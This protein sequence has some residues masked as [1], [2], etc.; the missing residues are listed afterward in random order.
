MSGLKNSADALGAE[1]ATALYGVTGRGIKIGIIS[2]SY[3]VNGSAAANVAAGNLPHNVTVESDSFVGSD[4]GQAMTELAYQ[5]APGASY[6]FATCG[7]SLQS[8]AAAVTTLQNAGCAVIVDDVTFPSEESFYQTGTVL[9]LAI[10]AAVAAGA[11]YFTA[12]GN[13]G[14]DYV[15]LGF[16]PISATVAGISP[17][18]LNAADFGGSSPYQ[19][20]AISPGADVTIDLEWAQPFATIGEGSGGAQNSLAFYLINSAG[21]VVASSTQVMLGDDPVQTIEFTNFTSSAQFRLVVVENGGTTPS[22][23]SFT[24]NVLDSALAT[25][26]GSDVG[27]GTGSVMGHALISGVNAVGA[28]TYNDTP[29]FGISP[30]AP[31]FYSA[32]GPGTILYSAQGQLLPIPIHANAPGFLSVSGSSTTVAGFAPFAGTSAAAPNAAAVGAL[33]LQA[34]GA[35]TNTEL[36]ALLDQSAIPVASTVDDVGA[37]LIQARAAVELSVAAAGARWSAA[38]GVYWSTTARWSAGA[39]PAA[40]GAVMLSDDLGTISGSYSLTVNSPTAVAGALTLSAPAGKTVTLII[41][42]GDGLAV[43]GPVTSD[44]TA[45]DFLVGVGGTL[46]MSGGTLS[47]T[48]S[49]N[50]NAGTVAVTGGNITAGNY[51]QDSGVMTLTAGTVA[52]TGAIGLAETGGS[53]SIGAQGVIDTTAVSVSAAIVSVAGTLDDLGI[54]STG[55]AG[56]L[57]TIS[58]AATGS[59]SIGGAASGVGIAFSGEG[60]LLDFTSNSSSVLTGGLTSIISGFDDGSSVVAFGALTYNPFDTTSYVDGALTIEDGATDLATLALAAS[61]YYGGFDLRAGT[62]DRLEVV[63]LACFVAGTCLWTERGAVA[64]ETLAVGDLV[65]TADNRLAP[66][67]WTG[68]RRIDCGRHRDSTGVLPVRVGAHAFGDGLPSRDLFLSP[69][70]AIFAE[71]VLIP[72]KHLI[73]GVLIRQVVVAHVT[74]VHIELAQHQLVLAEGLPV[75]SYLDTGD[76]AAFSGGPVVALHPEWGKGR[77]DIAM[78]NDALAYAPLRVMGA[79]VDRVRA[80]LTERAQHQSFGGNSNTRLTD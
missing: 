76:R 10:E 59:L 45:G 28:V 78:F 63:A 32:T 34:N 13:G 51:T 31:A 6:Y 56:G 9:D 14:D 52:L 3:S 26:E 41:A 46:S 50:L 2:D 80:R 53:V 40:N 49:L 5:V 19:D 21:R 39:L 35:L 79:E 18:A 68:L 44:I 70:H 17:F 29:A 23:Q 74:Y 47:V 58:I 22:G 48:G 75:E 62:G 33:M 77:G 67:I 24:I 4:E 43:G 20:I 12:T 37:G 16:S 15:Q 61:E 72:V 71:G 54:L 25:L 1:V 11:N 64:V 57:G 8:F 73:D 30:A 27:T 42:A 36:T 66:I 65:I 60:G 55:T 69:D 38:G 7:D